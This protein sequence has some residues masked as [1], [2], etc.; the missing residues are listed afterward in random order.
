MK[1]HELDAP[2]KRRA[3]LRL[4]GGFV[5]TLATAPYWHAQTVLDVEVDVDRLDYARVD[6]RGLEPKSGVVGLGLELANHDDVDVEPMFTTWDHR[7]KTRHRWAIERGPDVLAA[8]ERADYL[9]EA[10]TDEAA[11]LAGYRMQLTVWQLDEERWRS[12]HLTP[13]ERVPPL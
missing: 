7:R 4:L 2:V 1:P 11:V 6:R 12:I 3:A 10:P 8:G 13:Q 5:A 9:I